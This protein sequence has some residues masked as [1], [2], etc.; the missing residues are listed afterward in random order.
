M[1]ALQFHEHQRQARSLRLIPSSPPATLLGHAST[2]SGLHTGCS[3]VRKRSCSGWYADRYEKTKPRMPGL[4]DVLYGPMSAETLPPHGG[5]Q[6]IWIS[7]CTSWISSA[8]SYDVRPR[9]TATI[10]FMVAPPF[11][12]LIQVYTRMVFRQYQIHRD[13]K[14]LC[15]SC[16]TLTSP[17]LQSPALTAREGQATARPRPAKV[18]DS[19]F[20]STKVIDHSSLQQESITLDCSP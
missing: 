6:I 7:S 9:R 19:S 4:F 8:E 3:S 18:R 20:T 17:S 5:D 12:M 15:E 1:G 16:L 10:Y 14:Y 2:F 13:C 11:V